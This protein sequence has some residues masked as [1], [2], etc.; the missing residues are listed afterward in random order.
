MNPKY[1]VMCYV[2]IK[3]YDSFSPSV[4]LR[5]DPLLVSFLPLTHD[6]LYSPI[7]NRNKEI[8]T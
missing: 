2:E 3:L 7:P 5:L 4:V 8:I 1:R 6:V